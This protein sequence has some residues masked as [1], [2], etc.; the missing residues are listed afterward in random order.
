[1]RWLRA[2]RTHVCP[3]QDVGTY[4]ETGCV[5]LGKHYS[6]VSANVTN[7]HLISVLMIDMHGCFNELVT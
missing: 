6:R 3:R 1:M 4:K 2:R 5:A 7:F